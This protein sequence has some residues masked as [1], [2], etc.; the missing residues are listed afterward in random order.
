M[1]S[2]FRTIQWTPRNVLDIGGYKGTW[3]RELRRIVPT[4]NVTIVEPN[5]HPELRAL[6]VRVL[7]EVLSS[8]QGTVNW[9]SN[10]TTGDSI[11]KERTRHYASVTP[12]LRTTTTL[13]ALFPAET[14][15]FIKIDCQGAE[16]DILRGGVSVLRGTEL[17][18]LECP[19]AGQYNQNAPSFA[20]YIH[21]LDTLGF[22]PLE[23]TEQHRATGVL[24]QID[25]AFLRKSSPLWESIQGRILS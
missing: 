23:I 13:D 2:L 1:E 3:T 25:I 12:S 11:Y 22:A 16:L 18:L 21:T 24:F 4:A 17:L 8:K 9:Y 5:P 19:F 15:D 20:E 14:F 10:L 7:Y 6:G